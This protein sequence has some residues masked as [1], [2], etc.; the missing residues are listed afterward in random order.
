MGF[1]LGVMLQAQDEGR[2]LGRRRVM[3]GGG[4]P[5]KLLSGAEG[6]DANICFPSVN[7]IKSS[8]AGQDLCPDGGE[9]RRA[10][11]KPLPS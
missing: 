3:A 11:A 6:N 1:G 5:F 2:S 8:E 7:P 9:T 10:G 4:K